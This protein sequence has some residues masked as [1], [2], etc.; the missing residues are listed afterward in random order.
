[1]GTAAPAEPTAAS[2]GVFLW[3]TRQKEKKLI[4]D[5]KYRQLLKEGFY[6]KAG[7]A[8][9]RNHWKFGLFGKLSELFLSDV[10]EGSDDPKVTLLDGVIG[11]HG[12][13][14]AVVE[15]GHEE[16]LGQIVQ[17]LAHCQDVVAVGSRGAVDATAFHSAEK[18]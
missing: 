2:S 11:L 12:P 4:S 7:R 6:L 18:E 9:F 10:D 1:M 16:G 14:P 13:E 15:H 3:E 5:S 8:V 17:V